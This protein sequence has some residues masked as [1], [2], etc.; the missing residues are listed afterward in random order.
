MYT[1][2]TIWPC[3]I[4]CVPELDLGPAPHSHAH[5]LIG[6]FIHPLSNSLGC[7]PYHSKT[8]EEQS[9]HK[10]LGLSLCCVVKRGSRIGASWCCGDQ[11]RKEF[12]L[13]SALESQTEAQQSQKTWQEWCHKHFSH[14]FFF[15]FLPPLE[16][17]LKHPISPLSCL[18]L[19]LIKAYNELGTATE[20][21]DWWL[22]GPGRIIALCGLSVRKGTPRLD[23][24]RGSESE[25]GGKIKVLH[26]NL[27]EAFCNAVL[28]CLMCAALLEP[29]LK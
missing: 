11:K 13:L 14:K 2:H 6:I 1:L 7:E 12:T 29:A 5:T 8:T 3:T 20:S 22:Y 24:E 15:F 28:F 26:C 4:H 23:G 25:G 19:P 18:S 17:Q 9:H 16:A 27:W 10:Y 21:Q